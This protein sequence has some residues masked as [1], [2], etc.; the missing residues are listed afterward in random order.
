MPIRLCRASNDKRSNIPNLWFAAKSV[1]HAEEL[2]SLSGPAL[3]SFNGQDN[4]AHVPFGITA[5]IKFKVQLQDHD[6]VIATKLT[7]TVTGLREI[8]DAPLAD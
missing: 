1:K 8:K 7:P 3:T 5:A 2:A 4:K 6:F